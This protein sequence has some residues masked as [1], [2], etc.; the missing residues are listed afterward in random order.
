MEKSLYGCFYSHY[1][2]LNVQYVIIIIPWLDQIVMMSTAPPGVEREVAA[3]TVDFQVQQTAD[4][5]SDWL[6][7]NL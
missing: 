6:Q 4:T 7:D 2:T 5:D 3:N 1:K